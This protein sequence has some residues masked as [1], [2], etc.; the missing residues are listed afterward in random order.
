MIYNCAIKLCENEQIRSALNSDELL[1]KLKEN[2]IE[3]SK[4]KKIL[5]I[6]Q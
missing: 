3:A 2:I 5:K 6:K 1:N 4:K